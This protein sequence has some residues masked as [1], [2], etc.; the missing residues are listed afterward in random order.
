MPV[1]AQPMD[2]S[3][4]AAMDA[5]ISLTLST[6]CSLQYWLVALQGSS[7]PLVITCSVKKHPT[8]AFQG[9]LDCSKYFAYKQVYD[10]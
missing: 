4:L 7:S 5:Y 10:I 9:F 3:A 6:P 1:A 2:Q 8:S